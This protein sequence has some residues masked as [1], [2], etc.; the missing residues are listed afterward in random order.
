MSCRLFAAGVSQHADDSV[1]TDAARG[2]D[3]RE[4]TI[5]EEGLQ[6][7]SRGL[8]IGEV[9][10]PVIREAGFAC[11]FEQRPAARSDT[12]DDINARR[13]RTACVAVVVERFLAQLQ[14]VAENGDAPAADVRLPKEFKA[15]G[16][17]VGIRV[18]GFLLHPGTPDRNDHPTV[19]GRLEL[20]N[21]TRYAIPRDSDGTC[22]RNRRK[23]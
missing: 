1:E 7:R 17:P 11:A 19:G 20:T 2:L 16:H 18:V 13:Y 15:T 14:H 22:A 5:S 23:D 9:M 8:G 12:D 4:I 3:Q 6:K 21:P 10:K